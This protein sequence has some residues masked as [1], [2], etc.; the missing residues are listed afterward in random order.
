LLSKDK[1][2]YVFVESQDRLK[3]ERAMRLRKLRALIKRLKEL[4][5]YK[6]QL[7]RDQLLMAVWPGQRAGW[8]YL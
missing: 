1:E 2:L 8:A 3:K 5:N 4:Q 6:K 7:T